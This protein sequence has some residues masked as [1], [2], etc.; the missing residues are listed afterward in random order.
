MKID[1]D[2]VREIFDYNPETGALTW[3]KRGSHWF[4]KEAHRNVWNG[5]FA[6]KVA[7][8][9]DVR[10]YWQVRLQTRI[11]KAHRLIW[12]MVYGEWPDGA[13]DHINGHKSDNRISNLRV[14]NM[15]ENLQNMRRPY[16]NNQVGLMGVTR[17][18]GRYRATIVVNEKQKHLGGFD[19]P[20]EAHAAYINAKKRLHPAFAYTNR[21]AANDL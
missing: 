8:C 2:T 21:R 17:S 3:K 15:T 10:G 11:E 12:L 4:S 19:D 7:G 18:K 20:Q 14:A 5:R 13:I 16:R 9:F 6:G 1:A